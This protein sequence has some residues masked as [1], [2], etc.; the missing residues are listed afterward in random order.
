M[1]ITALDLQQQQFKAR[2]RGYDRL[3]VESFLGMVAEELETQVRENQA[4]REQLRQMEVEITRHQEREQM[5]KNTL[6]TAQKVTED[7]KDN[8]KKESQLLIKTAELKGEKILEQAQL[9]AAK[10]QEEIAELKR[11]RKLFEAKVRSAL[12]S[13]EELLNA[14]IEDIEEDKVRYLTP[15]EATEKK[16]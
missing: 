8:A 11:Q 2:F 12:R 3:E 16:G 6:M 5:L 7:L 4:L 1:R 9:R 10:V 14:T 15:R 13:H